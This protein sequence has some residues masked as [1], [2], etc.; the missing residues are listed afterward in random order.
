V[1][2]PGS[3]AEWWATK[4]A[5]NGRRAPQAPWGSRRIAVAS[6]RV[7]YPH[8]LAEFAGDGGMAASSAG[9]VLAVGQ[10][11]NQSGIILSN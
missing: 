1:A 11:T 7:G 8:H 4:Q 5:R 2:L 3:W 9:N 6:A 10:G